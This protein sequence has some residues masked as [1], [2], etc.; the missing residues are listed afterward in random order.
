MIV[1]MIPFLGGLIWL[2]AAATGMGALATH[3]VRREA[4][5]VPAGP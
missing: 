3:V 2:V 1:F 4:E 5:A